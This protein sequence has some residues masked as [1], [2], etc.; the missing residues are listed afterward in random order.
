MPKNIIADRFFLA[1]KAFIS[2]NTR[3]ATLRTL[4]TSFLMASCHQAMVRMMTGSL[5]KY[6]GFQARWN[7]EAQMKRNTRDQVVMNSIKDSC[8]CGCANKHR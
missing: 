1:I 7:P 8:A 5:D 3:Y 4:R 2:Y 6:V